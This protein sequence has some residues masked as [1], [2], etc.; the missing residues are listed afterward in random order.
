MGKKTAIAI[1]LT[2]GVAAYFA[3]RYLLK[4]KHR[5]EM[6]AKA[7]NLA[8][9]GSEK[10]LKYYRYA[11]D[12]FEDKNEFGCEFEN[13]KQ[14]F[15]KKAQD[16]KDNDNVNKAFDSLKDATSDLKKQFEKAK[17]D[18]DDL[19]PETDIVIDGRSAFGQAKQAAETEGDQ[20]TEVF[21]PQQD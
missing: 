7:N 3:T 9:E 4:D 6:I 20:P 5:E 18:Y 10:A 11:K 8:D 13:L 16:L 15:S 19:A 14:K 21:Y 12:Y 17:V 2:T 1:T